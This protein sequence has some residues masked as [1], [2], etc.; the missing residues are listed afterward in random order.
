[1][2]WEKS[3]CH[4]KERFQKIMKFCFFFEF[5]FDCFFGNIHFVRGLFYFYINSM[6]LKGCCLK[7]HFRFFLVF[8]KKDFFWR[9][10]FDRK[11]NCTRFISFYFYLSYLYLIFLMLFK[12]S[13]E[14]FLLISSRFCITGFLFMEVLLYFLY[15]NFIFGKWIGVL[16]DLFSD[17]W[18]IR[19]V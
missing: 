7:F 13:E 8:S 2:A 16:L 5:Q 12:I 10:S 19:W 4:R 1:M 15:I 9:G 18:G 3:S 14:Y 11:H 6:N 17:P